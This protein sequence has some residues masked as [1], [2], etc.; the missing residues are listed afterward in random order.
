M[1]SLVAPMMPKLSSM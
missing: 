1:F